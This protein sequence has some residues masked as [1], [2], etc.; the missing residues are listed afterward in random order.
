MIASW[1][2]PT[3]PLNSTPSPSPTAAKNATPAKIAIRG[4]K[5]I[6][7]PAPRYPPELKHSHWEVRGSG[8]YRVIFN[9]QGRTTNVEVV[10]STGNTLLDEAAVSALHQWRSEAGHDCTL[11]VPITFQP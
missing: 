4:S 9:G 11:V 5:V 3:L 10:R 1:Q 8:S 7:A 6:Y 2:T